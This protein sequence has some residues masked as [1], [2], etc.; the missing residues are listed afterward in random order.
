MV[1]TVGGRPRAP[2]AAIDR[3]E[4]AVGVGPLVPDGHAVLA[5]PADVGVTAQKPQQLDDDRA[6]V[7]LLG[8]DQREAL[9][10]IETQLPADHAAGAGAGAVG[11]HRAV[12]EHVAQQIEV[13]LH[14]QEPTRRRRGRLRRARGVRSERIRRGRGRALRAGQPMLTGSSRQRPEGG[15]P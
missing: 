2:L 13:G 4:F 7:Q 10:Q 3:S 14:G 12:L 8:R 11:L 1:A 6:Q 5:Q 9:R 15:E